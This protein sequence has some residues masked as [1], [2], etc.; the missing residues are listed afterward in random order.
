MSRLAPTTRG[1]ASDGLHSLGC[2]T[3]IRKHSAL[4]ADNVAETTFV[5]MR[6]WRQGLY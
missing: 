6:G 3:S 5:G 2:R 1:F 4:A